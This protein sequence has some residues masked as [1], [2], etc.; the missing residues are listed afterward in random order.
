[1]AEL[2]RAL[3]IALRFSRGKK[4]AGLVSLISIISTLGIVLGVAVLIIGLS[5]M[6]GFER[7]LKNRILS[8]VPHGQIAAVNQPYLNWQADLAKVRQTPGVVS[9]SPY[10]NFTGLLEKGNALKA[11][12]V[13]GVD[14]SSE[15]SVSSLPDFILNDA[16]QKLKPGNNEIILGQGVAETLKVSPG[17]HITIMIPNHDDKLRIQQPNRI[18]VTVI[19][20][21]KLNGM[22]DHQLAIVPLQDAQQYLAYG[23]GVTGFQISVNDVFAANKVVYDAGINTGHYVTIKSWIADYGYMYNDIQMVRGIMY[24]A[25]I[26]V[27]GVA[28]FNI[29]STLVMAVKD[30]STDIAVLR[31]LGAKDSFIRAIF[32]WYGLITGM[33]GCFIGMLVGIFISLNLT[34]IIK[35][36]ESIVGHPILSGDVY[37][38]DFLPSE[39]YITD[40]FY[41]MLTTLILSLLASW[42]PAKRAT[43]IDPAR[44][45]SGQ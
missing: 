26:L 19:G 24:L 44:I 32:L 43:K 5:A 7:E 21:F 1:M 3:K 18:S 30:K 9:V 14:L 13:A 38:I 23:D 10:I 28:C 29:V 33:V 2:P 15:R 25:M 22:L 34:T 35:C 4:R 37:F 42:Y 27:I 8:V 36:I 31:T 11:I 17:D 6:N 16:W 39:L 41:V 20:V 45:L 12:Q 40:V